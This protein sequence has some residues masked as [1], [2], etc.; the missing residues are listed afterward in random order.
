MN[1]QEFYNKVDN[2]LTD[3]VL[4][5][6]AT[7]D[8]NLQSY[9]KFLLTKEPIMAKPVFQNTFPWEPGKVVFGKTNHIF[10]ESFIN[11]LATIKEDD[12]CFPEDRYPYKHQLESW[13]YLLNKNQSIAVTTGT[14]SGKTECFMLPVLSD[15]YENCRNQVGVNA[16]FLYP[17]N[18]L[19]NSQE[20]RMEAW[21]NALGGLKYALL[22]GDTE[23]S[24]SRKVNK[25]VSKLATRKEIRDTPPNILFT[26]PTMLEYMLVRNKDTPI[27]EQS[28][29]KLRWI[30]LDEAHTLTG[31]KA[32][33]MA[34]LIRRVINAFGVHS[35]DLRFA[36]TS[37]TVGDDNSEY[38]KKFMANL[39]G[40]Q[41]NKII[42]I[43]GKRVMNQI[44]E[45]QLPD[46]N[47]TLTQKNVIKLRK[48]FLNNAAVTTDQIG[49]V[50]KTTDLQKILNNINFLAE[51]KVDDANV[52]PL[53]GHYFTRGIGGVYVCT[54]TKCTEHKE[55]KHK[56]PLGTSYTIAN[57]KC[58]CGAP[59]LE[60]VACNSC[61]KNVLEGQLNKDEKGER[62]ITQKTSKGYE[63]FHIDTEVEEENEDVDNQKKLAHNV[64][65]FVKKQKGRPNNNFESCSISTTGH[66]MDNGEEFWM[67]EEHSCPHCGNNMLHPMHFRLSSAF[68]NRILSDVILEQTQIMNPKNRSEYALNDG[69]KYIS[70]T[71]SRQGTAKIAALINNDKEGGYIRYQLYHQIIS[72]LN[73]E[74]V[75]D[76]NLEELKQSLAYYQGQLSDNPPPF[77]IEKIKF[78]IENVKKQ[79][80]N[81]GAV[82]YTEYG[83]TWEKFVG[84]I[85]EQSGF[86]TLFR[87]VIKGENIVENNKNYAYALLYD[88]FARRIPRERSLENIGLVNLYYPDLEKIQL[89]KLAEN[90]EITIEDWKSLLSIAIDYELRYNQRFFM[91]DAYKKYTT[92][93]YFSKPIFP[94]NTE[95][96]KVATWPQFNSKSIRQS[97]L[98]LL[99]CAGLGWYEKEQ[100]TPKQEDVINELLN[101]L[102]KQLQQHFLT[103]D[104]K[105]YKLSLEEKAQFIVGQKQYLCPVTKR[106]IN[107]TFKGYSPWIK[108]NVSLENIKNY[109]LKSD[110]IT[111]P[112]FPY[113]NHL[114]DK[115]EPI[116]KSIV[117]DWL[118]ENSR[119]IKEQGIWND[120][121]ERIYNSNELFLAG[122]HSAQQDK[123]R[124]VELEE[125][126]EKGEVNILSCSTT[127]E[128]GV[129]IGGISAVVMSNVPPMPSNYLQRAGRAGRR[130]ENKSLALTFC[131]PNPIGLKAMN[132]PSWA[133]EHKIAPPILSFDSKSIVIRHINSLLFGMF[134]RHK[135]NSLQ[136][137]NI[138]ENIETF[139]L[140]ENAMGQKFLNWLTKK[141]RLEDCKTPINR[142]I[143]NILDFKEVEPEQLI[144][145]AYSNFSK[146]LIKVKKE[147]TNYANKLKALAS[148][149]GDNS[150][151]YKAVNYRK[152]QFLK[153]NILN[154]L[155]EISF[156]PN[157][158]LPTGIIE[159][160]KTTIDEVKKSKTFKDNPS[161]PIERALTE[162]APGNSILIDGFSYKSDGILLKNDFN[163]QGEKTVVQGCTNCGFQR[164]VK[165]SDD[166]KDECP[167]CNTPSFKGVDLGDHKGAF[168]EVIEPVGFATSLLSNKTRVIK[169]KSK[170]EY[171][172]PLLLGLKPWSLVQ[173]NWVDFRVSSTQTEAEI[174]FYNTGF[175]NGYSVCLD[176]G[177]VAGSPEDLE[178]HYR[179]RGG[180]EANGES[181]CVAKNT[182]HNVILGS[183][184]KTD[185]TE[186][187][188]KDANENL[189]DEDTLAYT[190]GVVITKSFANYLGIEEMELGFGIKAYKNYKTLFIYDTA[191]GG[192]G[193]ATQLSFYFDEVIAIAKSALECTCVNACT[194]C[195][196]DRKTQWNIENLNRELALEYLNNISTTKIPQSILQVSPTAKTITGSLLEE[197]NRINY[198]HR[199]K[200]INVFVNNK[201]G[202]WDVDGLKELS[203]YHTEHI[204]VNLVINGSLEAI[205]NQELLTLHSLKGRFK[206]KQTKNTTIADHNIHLVLSLATEK[207]I[208]Y[209]A[210]DEHLNLDNLW[211]KSLES[212]VF[213]LSDTQ[214]L[215]L[216]DATLPIISQEIIEAKITSWP[217][218]AL[219]DQLCNQVFSS[220]TGLEPFLEKLKGESFTINYI[221]NYNL[222]EFSLRLLVQF[223]TA[224]GNE[225]QTTIKQLKIQVNSGTFKRQR[226]NNG[227]AV[228]SY[229]DME[230]YKQKAQELETAYNLEIEVVDNYKLPHYRYFEFRSQNTSFD[231]RVDGGIAHGL[232]PVAYL[233]QEE[234]SNYDDVMP[235]KKYVDHSLIYYLIKNN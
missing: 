181:K 155:S 177:K 200:E 42:V 76:V 197:L 119:P 114:S 186:L 112:V 47:N 214:V 209:I 3:A 1:F 195:L 73:K 10:K 24:K 37:A 101:H 212:N 43:K 143:H 135:D 223:V 56:N 106:L 164:I 160:D 220:F 33:E 104:D 146:V 29:G 11:A 12:F 138:K 105:G 23:E 229:T 108:G 41:Q 78:D 110:D 21:C 61:G 168:T 203:F 198:H 31:S 92:K 60:M 40:I 86:K 6:W 127:M 77:L 196:I 153:K 85:V 14:G 221:D 169:E 5:L 159:F 111:L 63:A 71:D 48:H 224:F 88:Q 194:N 95:V 82:D 141:D 161:Y 93:M 134:I 130:S 87:K 80:E 207:N 102:W 190:L 162:F 84:R 202:N 67:T 38:I 158:G 232:S 136:G 204:Q 163:A 193:Y 228:D 124:L 154:Y 176:C 210:K 172:E 52:L 64:V 171:L 148:E 4:S 216:N 22:T 125:Q 54:N 45:D 234:L 90:Y 235:V 65:R 118:T 165:V 180:K 58:K 131:P 109:T 46:Y 140:Q 149:F 70:F 75:T 208:S 39:F 66:I 13:D 129:D 188:F 57:K 7:G 147:E 219:S 199:I 201:V 30:L 98:V 182:K 79:L 16:I 116:D 170:P 44:Q 137:L 28:K 227:Y 74:N 166:V 144:G 175:G 178:G 103:A 27:L 179:L 97:R 151:A 25:S 32:T 222:S 81:N 83:L 230:Q 91:N 215:V 53:R 126:F 51:Q 121:H 96:S 150:P 123:K 89:P 187:R 185:F 217:R 142:V 113:A 120:L 50:F 173:S 174:L 115:N 72:Q 226:S 62:I 122:E 211:F 68:T 117:D 157:A 167:E 19:I 26:N 218:E 128:M 139:F 55:H 15:L 100:I 206:L 35:S 20:K 34:L 156:L 18:A 8:K 191:K 59:L 205:T 133:L 233:K 145:T 192:A 2:R 213:K 231:V 132:N 183:K 49:K 184:F 69:R 225:Y 107:N 17:L 152:N 9:L 36:I 99:L 94:H 189:L